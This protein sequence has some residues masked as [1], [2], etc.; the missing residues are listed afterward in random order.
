AFRLDAPLHVLL[1]MC[2]GT[3]LARQR[4]LGSAGAWATGAFYGLS[5]FLLS[6]ANILQIFHGAAWAPWVVLAVLRVHQRADARRCALLALV[7]ALQ[8]STLAVDYV[9]QTAL[10]ALF[11]LP[12]RVSRRS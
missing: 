11:L 7:L 5:G 10:V 6:S 4:G 3:A 12:S 9:L 2:G 8:V 1:A